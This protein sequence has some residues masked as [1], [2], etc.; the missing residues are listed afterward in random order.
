ML[1]Q[2]VPVRVS[3]SKSTSFGICRQKMSHFHVN[4]RQIGHIF[5][6]FKM[7]LHGA[8][9]RFTVFELSL[10]V[11]DKKVLISQVTLCSYVLVT[12]CSYD[13][14]QTCFLARILQRNSSTR[15]HVIIGTI[16][17]TRLSSYVLIF[18]FNLNLKWNRN[19]LGAEANNKG[20]YKNQ[21]G[22]TAD[23]E[24]C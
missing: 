12:L 10:N 2:I 21:D 3:L 24:T 13:K 8:F 19:K 17:L 11:T 9:H 1:F 15:N 23:Q 16:A 18:C 4:V 20:N 14:R 6:V 7:L 22:R 5:T